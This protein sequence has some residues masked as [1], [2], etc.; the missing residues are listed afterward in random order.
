MYFVYMSEVLCTRSCGQVQA[1]AEVPAAPNHL[2]RGGDRLLLQGEVEK[3]PQGHVQSEQVSHP[4]R[5]NGQNIYKDTK[6]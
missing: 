6:P 3:L 5:T 1:A 4:L 2:G